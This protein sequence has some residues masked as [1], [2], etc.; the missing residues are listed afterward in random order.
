MMGSR[1]SFLSIVSAVV[2]CVTVARG[3]SPA[4]NP[5]PPSGAPAPSSSG[6]TTLSP[7]AAAALTKR[8]ADLE[9]QVDQLTALANN[10]SKMLRDAEAFQKEQAIVNTNHSKMLRDIATA[11]PSSGSEQRWVPNVQAIRD[12][13]ASRQAL[14]DT[15]AE[16]ITRATGELR[17]RNDMGVG[18]SLVIN[19]L[20]VVYVAPHATR[21]VTVPS[22]TATT[23]LRGS[24]EGTMSWAVGAPNYFQ[25]V[26]IAP[27][28]Q[29]TVVAANPWQ[30]DPL[31]GSWFRTLP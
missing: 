23:Q 11:R 28:V 4:E 6:S 3:E 19:G 26:I 5:V 18:Q 8:V 12:D 14:V 24:G 15:V 22:G 21:M 2:L 29:N 1:I 10:Q 20:D 13:R 31:T 16:G 27:A 7:A 9:Q 30:Y 25:E 17:I